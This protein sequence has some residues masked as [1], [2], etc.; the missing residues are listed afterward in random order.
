MGFFESRNVNG[1]FVVF[2]GRVNVQFTRCRG[3]PKN[4]GKHNGRR[5]SGKPF[6]H[7]LHFSSFIPG[8][9]QSG[10]RKFKKSAR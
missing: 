2:K 7:F 10:D 3:R 5:E 1:K 4:A 8:H 9:R 6:Q